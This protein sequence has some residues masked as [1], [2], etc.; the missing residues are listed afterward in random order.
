M[1][2][3]ICFLILLMVVTNVTSEDYLL[4]TLHNFKE[5]NGFLC[6]TARVFISDNLSPS[7]RKTT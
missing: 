6:Y 7:S 5:K 2:F 1:F 4:H 3:V